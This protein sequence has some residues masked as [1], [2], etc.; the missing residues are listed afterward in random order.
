MY[1]LFEIVFRL[2]FMSHEGVNLMPKRYLAV[3]F[4]SLHSDMEGLRP[5]FCIKLSSGEPSWTE[6]KLPVNLATLGYQKSISFKMV[7]LGSPFPGVF[8]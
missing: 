7:Y 4:L 1:I 3:V 6:E 5:T 2:A 8:S